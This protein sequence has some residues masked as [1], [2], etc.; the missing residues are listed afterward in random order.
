MAGLNRANQR[1]IDFLRSTTL[2]TDKIPNEREGVEESGAQY[3]RADARANLFTFIMTPGQL[4]RSP[5]N[6]QS[7]QV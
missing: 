3:S 5:R 1:W 4:I 2:R 7:W 6:G